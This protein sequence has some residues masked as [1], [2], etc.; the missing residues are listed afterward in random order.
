MPEALISWIL[1]L[2]NSKRNSYEDQFLSKIMNS[3]PSFSLKFFGLTHSL[4]TTMKVT[5]IEKDDFD[6]AK[7][8]KPS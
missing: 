1:P 7:S 3:F 2:K 6:K 5:F 4:I 8:R